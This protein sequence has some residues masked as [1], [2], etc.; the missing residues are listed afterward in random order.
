M[1]SILTG[2]LQKH[3]ILYRIIPCGVKLERWNSHHLSSK[4]A[5]KYQ[6]IPSFKT[7]QKTMNQ[8]RAKTENQKSNE[9]GKNN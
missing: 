6:Q 8:S 7:K 2:I 3:P 5:K 1:K 9:Q 4:E